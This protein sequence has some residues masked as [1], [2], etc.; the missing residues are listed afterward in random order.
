LGFWTWIT[1]VFGSNTVPVSG[2]DLQAVF[3][4]DEFTYLLSD[5][6]IKELAFNSAVNIIA[7]AVSKCEFKT[8]HKN[9][10]KKGSEYYLWNVEPNLNQNSNGFIHKWIYQLYRNNEAL[11]VQ[12][13]GQLLVADTFDRTPYVKYG[14]VFKQVTVGNFVF[15]KSFVQKDVMYWQLNSKDMRKVVGGLYESY[16]KLI[17]YS[18]KAY[19]KS[20]G[21]KGKFKY[22]ALPIKGSRE[23]AA[24]NDLINNKFKSFLEAD[25][26]ILPLGQGQDITDFTSKT[27]S[28]EATRDIRALIDDVCDF[29]AKAFCIPPALL[30]GDV[31]GTADAV[32]NLLT[33]CVDPLVDMLQVEIN[34]KRNGRVAYLAGTYLKIDTTTVMHVDV[35]KSAT[36]IDKLVGSGVYSINGILKKLGEPTINEPWADEH[37]ITRNYSTLEEV[38]KALTGGGEKT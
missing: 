8:F 12:S 4:S 35:L 17:A 33:F 32:D 20:R 7:N 38:L 25:N 16:A 2:D 5:V 27:Y 1:S 15:S 30:R 3:D 13:G 34:R 23:E 28:N 26:A 10:E 18:M 14:D 6:Y 37:F 9:I 24:F 22:D 21:F 31:Q 19:Q 36:S 29:Y 11:I